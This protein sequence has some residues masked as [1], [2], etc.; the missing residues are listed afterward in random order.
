MII[1]FSMDSN[2]YFMFFIGKIEFRI[3]ALLWIIKISVTT[4]IE[5]TS[6]FNFKILSIVFFLSIC[7]TGN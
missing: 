7:D 5:M 1:I 3:I 4:N 2:L 6:N